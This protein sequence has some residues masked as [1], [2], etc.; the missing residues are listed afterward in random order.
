MRFYN[1]LTRQVEPFAPQFET[2]TVYVCGITPYD[3]THLGHAFTYATADLLVRFLEYQGLVVR[4][5][6]NVTDIDDDILRK[7]REVGEPWREL[8]NRW[9]AHFISDMKALNIRPPDYFPRATEAIEGIVASVERL[10]EAGVAYVAGGSVYYDL[11]S[12]P[13]YGALSGL[14]KEQMLPV[15]NERGNHPDD[16]NK[17]DPLDFVLWQ[18][19]A[20]GEPGWDSPWGPGRPGWHIECST[21]A[22][23]YLGESIDIHLGGAD[24]VFPHHESEIAQV[25]PLTGHPFARLWMH[26]AMVRHEGEKMSK[27]LGNL[28]MVRDLLETWSPDALRL[29]LGCHHYREPWAYEPERLQDMEA[30]ARK[31]ERVVSHDG[32]GEGGL[33]PA[34]LRERFLSALAN[35]LDSAAA[36]EALSKLADQI[37]AAGVSGQSVGRAQ[38]ALLAMGSVLGLRMGVHT[39][40][41]GSAEGWELH[42]ARYLPD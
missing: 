38:G 18:A 15:A 11:S 27:S 1:T 19:Q 31:L 3:T 32:D 4:Y 26:V 34:P 17:R 33:D 24:L 41:E 36:I 10:L 23:E 2:V 29:Y 28:V 40:G 42:L 22:N 16:P 6:Q 12:W 30:L 21:M 20:S 5:T 13:A 37:E 25:E 7:A 35:D 14:T 9:T 8:G 39:L